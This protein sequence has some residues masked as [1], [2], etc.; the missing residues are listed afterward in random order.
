MAQEPQLLNLIPPTDSLLNDPAAEVGMADIRSVYVQAVIDRMLELAA[1]KGHNAKD[2]RQMVGLAAPQ[3]GASRRI[4]IID[5]TADGSHKQQ[6]FQIVINP[7]LT[8]LSEE[9]MVGREGCWSAGKICGIVERSKYAT[10]E[11]FDRDGQQIRLVLS[12]FV[13]RIAQHEVD[14]LD[15][16]R[17]P[18][19]IPADKPER[20]HWVE[21]QQ[22]NRY[23]TEWTDW[24]NKCPRSV[25]VAMKTGSMES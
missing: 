23:R 3:I 16:I 5:V 22:F 9:M 17:F 24:P 20:L 11:G 13:A 1:G 8:N 14:H 7:R 15:G 6:Y 2:S 12:D 18:D 10:L 25:W 4:I 19:R 21:P